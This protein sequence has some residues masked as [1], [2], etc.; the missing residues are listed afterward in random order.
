M[1][2]G[3]WGEELYLSITVESHIHFEELIGDWNN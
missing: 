3:G 1:G 2:G